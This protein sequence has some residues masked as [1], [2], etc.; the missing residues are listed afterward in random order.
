M[1][2]APKGY[3]HRVIERELE[4]Q[5]R[6]FGGVCIEGPMW[7]GK[8][9]LG[10]NASNSSFEIGAIDEYGQDNRDLVDMNVHVAMEGNPPHLIDEWQEVPKLW[11]AVRSELDHNPGKGR[12]ILTG[13]SS[14]KDKRPMHSGTGRIKHIRMR[15]MSLWE[16]GESTGKIS[17]NSII[18]GKAAS[19]LKGGTTLEH[20]VDLTIS[21]GWPGNIGLPYEDRTNSV[22]GYL[23]S[24]VSK[25]ANLDGIHRKE[26]NMWMVM[27]SLARNE[28]TL[29]DVSKIRIT[30]ESRFKTN[31]II[32]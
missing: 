27:R 15:T 21:G 1:G 19:N 20:L 28:S 30:M 24:V 32:M 18:S 6:A 7:C 23:E 29:A 8:T 22:R 31:K 13:S 12:Y 17:L 11:D 2:L 16:S 10:L 4:D 9:W 3:R 5:L 26:S 25:A 14:P